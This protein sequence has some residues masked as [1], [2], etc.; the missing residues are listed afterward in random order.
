MK[1]PTKQ[2]IRELTILGVVLVF[3]VAWLIW[4]PGEGRRRYFI[5]LALLIV[6]MCRRK[7]GR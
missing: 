6:M 3:V 4:L 5:T 1:R 2:Q 7:K